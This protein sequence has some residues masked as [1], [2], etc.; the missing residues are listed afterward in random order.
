MAAPGRTD[1]FPSPYGR[2]LGAEFEDAGRLAEMQEELRAEEVDETA[3]SQTG[4]S[5]N[6]PE[7]YTTLDSD[8]VEIHVK[9]E[10]SE[11]EDDDDDDEDASTASPPVEEEAVKPKAERACY[12]LLAMRLEHEKAVSTG[13]SGFHCGCSESQ[14]QGRASCLD[15]FS[16]VALQSFYAEIH[17]PAQARRSREDV[18]KAHHNAIWALRVLRNSPD[19]RGNTI[20]LPAWKLGGVQVCQTAWVK[21]LCVTLNGH[22]VHRAMTIK[23]IGPGQEAGARLA[24]HGMKAFRRMKATRGEWASQ[25]WVVHLKLHDYLPNETAI[26][27]RGPKWE[28][29]YAQVYRPMAALADMVCC[30]TTWYEARLPALDM[31]NKEYHNGETRPPGE[32]K[33][34]RSP[35]HSRFA[36]CNACAVRKKAYYKLASSASSS[37][38]AIDAAY[39]FLLE[40]MKE[41]QDDRAAAL[42]LK[43][44]SSRQDSDTLYENDDK[45]GSHWQCLPVNPTGRETKAGAK[46]QFEFSIQANVVFGEGGVQMFSVTPKTV[47]T[48]GNFGLTNF[49]MVLWRAKQLGRLN[50]HVTRLVRHTDGGPDNV[51]LVTHLLHWLLV[52]IGAFQEMLW[53]RF[54]AGHSHTELSDRLFS[55]LKRLF[56]SDNGSRVEGIGDFVE[57]WHK[58]QNLLLRSVEFK[59]LSWCLANWNFDVWF[60]G[61][62]VLGS[63]SRISAVMVFK[64]EYDQKLWQH[65]GVRVTYKERLSATGA[66]SREAEFAPMC[67]RYSRQ[68]PAPRLPPAPSHPLH[69]PLAGTEGWG[70]PNI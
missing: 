14:R 60:D 41:W 34:R 52:Y 53:F 67:E 12:A 3:V 55:V 36:E 5:S 21:A 63:Y 54:E 68:D 69:S 23:G 61:M 57:L 10:P 35:N 37:K 40:H 39:A 45:C 50:P 43:Y 42:K 29:V 65:G 18:L 8:G 31:L 26:Q 19:R 6:A 38:P 59:E 2:Q 33:C 24:K 32:L 4:L 28:T 46:N 51:A 56:A 20:H 30:K 48:G 47:P 15:M 17:G 64:Y 27:I 44:E 62:G 1:T 58:L 7:R 16:K 49:V 66:H 11:I 9:V 25:W 22:R 70:S 13:F